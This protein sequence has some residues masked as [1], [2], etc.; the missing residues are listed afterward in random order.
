M[1]DNW[2]IV[3]VRAPFRS[4]S[5]VGSSGS[6]DDNPGGNMQ[7]LSYEGLTEFGL[8][9][10]TLTFSFSKVRPP[11]RHIVMN[12]RLSFLILLATVITEIE[13]PWENVNRGNI[14]KI[15]IFNH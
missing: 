7:L 9:Y 3:V 15:I 1:S 4:F 2:S 13:Y 6:L 11:Q 5:D 10:P 8:P 12:P 14:L